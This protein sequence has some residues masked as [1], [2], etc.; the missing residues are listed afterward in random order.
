MVTASLALIACSLTDLSSL[1]DR[2][3]VSADTD[4]D[5]DDG[6]DGRVPEDATTQDSASDADV[7][8]SD[9][10]DGSSDDASSD[11]SDDAGEAGD[12]QV[13]DAQVDAAEAGPTCGMTLFKSPSDA[14]NVYQEPDQGIWSQNSAWSSPKN[15]LA[16]DSKFAIGTATASASQHLLVRGFGFDLDD[17]A[18]IQGVEVEM[19]RAGSSGGV[20]PEGS[21][22]DH[23]LRLRLYDTKNSKGSR[24]VAGVW[25][26]AAATI[27]YGNATDTWD[28]SLTG[29][30]VNRPDFGVLFSFRA[31]VTTAS[32]TARVDTIRVRLHYCR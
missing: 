15:A 9:H 21:V 1:T 27:E 30:I 22:T 5:A 29:T 16:E 7:G 32:S 3:L 8:D 28:E 12:A 25:P 26:S 23:A 6:A 20:G 31:S 18:V 17:D 2:S 10:D 4:A 14:V 24:T 19:V 11:A 13:D